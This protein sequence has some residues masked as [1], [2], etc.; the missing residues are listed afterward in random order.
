MSTYPSPR[1]A[2]LRALS[3]LLAIVSTSALVAGCG[4]APGESTPGNPAASSA[5]VATERWQVLFMDG[6]E[7]GYA[8]TTA[9][10][11]ERDGQ[12][13]RETVV[14][15]QLRM[16]RMGRT[17][18]IRTEVTQLEDE[19]GQLTRYHQVL[20]LSQ[21]ET[22]YDGII[23]GD[24]MQLKVTTQG[25]P[26]TSEIPWEEDVPGPEEVD[27]RVAAA[28]SG[29]TLVFHQFDPTLG[30]PVEVTVNIGDWETVRVNDREERLRR[31]TLTLPGLPA[32]T[33]WVDA[34]G[35][36]RRSETSLMGMTMLT[37]AAESARVARWIGGETPPAEVFIQSTITANVRLPRPRS[38]D[39]ITYLVTPKDGGALPGFVS[40][41]QR[42][43]AALGGNAA[44]LRISVLL[45]PASRKQQVVLSEE[46]V[47]DEFLA[48]N[49][50]IQS[51]DPDLRA[52]AIETIGA[53]T[54][55]WSAAQALE[56]AVYE[57]IDKKSMDV[58]FASAAETFDTR[59]GDC[60][61]HAVLLSA[62]TRSVGVPSRVAMGLVYVGGI[63]GGH[64]WTE[65]RIDDRWY[66]LDATIGR[67]SVDPTH[68]A[69]GYASLRDG[70]FSAGLIGV[71]S[72]LGN[73]DLQIQEYS[74]G[75]RT[76]R[77]SDLSLI[78]EVTD[79]VFEDPREGVRFLVP[80]GFE[81]TLPEADLLA[82]SNRFV[83]IELRAGDGGESAIRLASTQV[84]YN[85]DLADFVRSVSE[86]VSGAVTDQGSHVSGHPARIVS[87]R[88]GESERFRAAILAGETLYSLEGDALDPNARAGFLRVLQ[89][90]QI[91]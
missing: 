67:G 86:G 19:R 66:A 48:P 33:S 59:T 47:A 56:R 41:R 61:E 46:G 60:S 44:I 36:A 77:V 90:L 10:S 15:N 40:D 57:R 83:M 65:V 43:L 82:M 91:R 9:R 74:Q 2:V 80:D 38:I 17:V 64:A 37:E 52:F 70:A 23:V 31:T 24:V 81:S 12:S 35:S 39:S 89:T 71:L 62:L 25:K 4:D 68:I 32:T 79:G 26:R 22:V 49:P 28:E 8:H 13:L 14:D 11:V 87:W 50:M 88:E 55:A 63:F 7:A 20:D 75:G 27:R 51:D 78:P 53:E 73:L 72:G 42:I 30:D 54:D 3:L 21:V 34:S 76:F 29:A 58:A 6:H 69:M 45:P 84:P 1:R 85:Y 5:E 16:Q 18:E